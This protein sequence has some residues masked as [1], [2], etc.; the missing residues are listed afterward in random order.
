LKCEN[1]SLRSTKSFTTI[2]YSTY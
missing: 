1:I 2:P